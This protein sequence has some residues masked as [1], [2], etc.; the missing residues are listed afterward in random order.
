MMNA[1]PMTG[2]AFDTRRRALGLSISE[3]AIVCGRA[4]K[5]VAERTIHRWT[6][7]Q[8][9]I[10]DDVAEA[11]DALE[12]R[13]DEIVASLVAAATD[14]TMDGPIAL[15][16]YR[17]QDELAASRD[18]VGIPLG[19]HAVMTAWLDAALAAEGVDTEIVWAD[20][21]D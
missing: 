6:N 3:A 18:D 5:P 8:T 13:M 10:P 16:R 14:L 20:E 11:L 2:A 15:P 21:I 4:G 7:G 19:A 1:A 17:T 9:Q 12:E